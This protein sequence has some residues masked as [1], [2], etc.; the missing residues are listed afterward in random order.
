MKLQKCFLAL[1]LMLLLLMAGTSA[2]ADVVPADFQLGGKATVTF[3]GSIL[4]LTIP[5]TGAYNIADDD[6][7]ISST[8]T[9]Q[10]TTGLWSSK[11]S[12]E[13]NFSSGTFTL[14]GTF[15]GNPS[16]TLL[17]GTLGASRIFTLGPDS[18]YTTSAGNV[19]ATTISTAVANYYWDSVVSKAL[20]GFNVGF[21]PRNGGQTIA[22][23]LSNPFYFDGMNGHLPK[24]LASGD[25]QVSP[26]PI[27][28]SFMLLGPG[29]A[30]LVMI[31]KRIWG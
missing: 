31:R 12:T 9:L 2:M 19:T 5:I 17:A 8:G 22:L 24:Q 18:Y 16:T 1:G 14:T 7:S 11:S 10:F 25:I 26:V 30:G 6:F 3:D 20:G 4:N 29:L 23:D 21:T 15:N 27:P 28:G 13:I